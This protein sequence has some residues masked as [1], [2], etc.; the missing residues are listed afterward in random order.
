MIK[1]DS[2]VEDVLR[3]MQE[4]VPVCRLVSV[5]RSVAAAAPLLW[6]N[7]ANASLRA[8]LISPYVEHTQSVSSE[9]PHE[10]GCVGDGFVGEEA[11]LR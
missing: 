2:D 9:S 1:L 7:G 11:R 5:S 3:F 8:P 4:H 6:G 10:Q